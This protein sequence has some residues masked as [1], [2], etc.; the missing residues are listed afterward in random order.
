LVNLRL[1]VFGEI[2]KAIAASFIESC[3]TQRVTHGGLTKPVF[4]GR[5]LPKVPMLGKCCHG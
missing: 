1:T 3:I 2:P 4:L 5:F